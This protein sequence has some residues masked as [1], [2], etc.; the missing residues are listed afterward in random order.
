MSIVIYELNSSDKIWARCIYGHGHRALPSFQYRPNVIQ[1]MKF[2]LSDIC[3][4]FK[5]LQLF[6]SFVEIVQHPIVSSGGHPGLW[7]PTTCA[8]A[9][10]SW[11]QV[12]KLWFKYDVDLIMDNDTC[13]QNHKAYE[14]QDKVFFRG[15]HITHISNDNNCNDLYVWSKWF[16]RLLLRQSALPAMQTAFYRLPKKVIQNWSTYL[17]T[18]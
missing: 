14:Q 13:W 7:H 3:H 8:Q 18:M 17:H 16:P 6:C 2:T 9:G 15:Y 5:A 4:W 11:L 10:M 1:V 12:G